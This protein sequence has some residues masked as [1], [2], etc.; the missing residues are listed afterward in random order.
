MVPGKDVGPYRLLSAKPGCSS[1]A[2]RKLGKEEDRIGIPI[3]MPSGFEL[4][5]FIGQKS[6]LAERTSSPCEKYVDF[7]PGAS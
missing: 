1:E 6:P 5:S 3:V 7:V 2:F 4:T